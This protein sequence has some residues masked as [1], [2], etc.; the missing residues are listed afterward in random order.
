M[1][2]NK[3]G[4]KA[5]GNAKFCLKCGSRLITDPV[6]ETKSEPVTE[7]KTDPV[8]DT[9]IPNMKKKSKKAVIAVILV[10]ILSIAVV[11]IVM[12]SGILGANKRDPLT[13]IT[14]EASDNIYIGNNKLKGTLPNYTNYYR[15]LWKNKWVGYD[16]DKTLWNI[17]KDGAKQIIYDVKQFCISYNGNSVIAVDTE[18]TLLKY[19]LNKKEKTKLKNELVPYNGN[20]YTAVSPDGEKYLYSDY[21]KNNYK[22]SLYIFD[23][24]TTEKV[25][26]YFPLAVAD[27]LSIFAYDT[28]H[29]LYY[30]APTGDRERIS[31]DF[32]SDYMCFFN[33][34][35]HELLFSERSGKLYFY[36]IGGEKTK[37]C[38]SSSEFYYDTKESVS[39]LTNT[40]IS[41]NK[42][43]LSGNIFV[44]N[45]NYDYET[46]AT[47]ILIDKNG[48]KISVPFQNNV[49]TTPIFIPNKG[50]Y[51]IDTLFDFEGNKKEFDNSYTNYKFV[52]GTQNRFIV[53]SSDSSY[54][55]FFENTETGEENLIC[56]EI[57]SNMICIVGDKYAYFTADGKICYSDGKDVYKTDDYLINF[58]YDR[59]YELSM[60]SYYNKENNKIE[61][62][63]VHN[64]TPENAEFKNGDEIPLT[65]YSNFM[66]DTA[67]QV[68]NSVNYIFWNDDLI[69]TNNYVVMGSFDEDGVCSIKINNRQ[70]TDN[71][72]YYYWP[73]TASASANSICGINGTMRIASR[74][75]DSLYGKKPGS[76]ILLVSDNEAVAALYSF[77]TENPEDISEFVKTYNGDYIYIEQIKDAIEKSDNN[78][79]YITEDGYFI[80]I[81]EGAYYGK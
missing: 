12:F 7:I 47:L 43:H 66:S 56:N 78:A 70:F 62:K 13:I 23:G 44:I 42:P 50:L 25:G 59:Y 28:E 74:I 64:G 2:C 27:D 17:D 32:N 57:D 76:F 26:S 51:I 37:L 35:N 52:N 41:I 21:D 45:W 68:Y 48:E 53:K 19:D 16:T 36:A 46:K 38:D 30:F 61:M 29:N 63:Y 73:E 60:Y 39:E 69:N 65:Y 14:S 33:N 4:T 22:N 71:D 81:S 72:T 55:L 20:Y 1:F 31:S 79:K 24:S 49:W 58:H 10:I 67:N 80:G 15:S 54:Q 6:T 3:C 8:L 11:V 77:D 40:V 5:E 75:A 18:G 34:N 9:V